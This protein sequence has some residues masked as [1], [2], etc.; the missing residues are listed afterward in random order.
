MTKLRLVLLDDDSQIIVDKLKKSAANQEGVFTL[1]IEAT[2]CPKT[3]RSLC[4]ENSGFYDF[5]LMDIELGDGTNSLV[6]F[7]EDVQLWSALP[8]VVLSEHIDDDYQKRALEC[9]AQA[10]FDKRQIGTFWSSARFALRRAQREEDDRHRAATK[11]SGDRD[12]ILASLM[13][14]LGAMKG[15]LDY[16]GKEVRALLSSH[17]SDGLS[18]GGSAL[19]KRMER[20]SKK[21]QDY[22]Y[23]MKRAGQQASFSEQNANLLLEQIVS[24]LDNQDDPI[25]VSIVCEL[26]TIVVDSAKLQAILENLLRNAVRVTPAE[27]R[28]QVEMTSTDGP[29]PNIGIL[30]VDVSDDGPGVG[31]TKLDLFEPLVRGVAGKSFGGMG[32][33]LA[34]AKAECRSHEVSGYRG[35]IF[36]TDTSRGAR[37]TIKLPFPK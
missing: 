17:K 7:A 16:V 33:G 36:Y 13:H 23:W 9:G 12:A 24:I 28:I 15:E 30:H 26:D 4:V 31:S 5:A 32:L 8:I 14:Q 29:T 27:G 21:L 19:L 20:V 11:L 34:I 3:F 18:V 1:D 2:A 6:E 10:Y 35:T 37:F 25:E 22:D